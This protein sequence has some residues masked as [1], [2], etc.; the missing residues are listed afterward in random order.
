M[1]R[2]WVLT[3]L[4]LASPFLLAATIMVLALITRPMG[5]RL[6]HA[7]ETA[8]WTMGAQNPPL[9]PN[10]MATEHEVHHA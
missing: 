1:T 7:A 6:G 3:L 5:P 2:D 9:A 10:D 4:V 8:R